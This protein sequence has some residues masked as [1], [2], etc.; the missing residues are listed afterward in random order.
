MH[1]R[2][3][4]ALE[5]AE[6]DQDAASSHEWRKQIKALWYGLR[7]LEG[8]GGAISR[9]IAALHRAEAWLGDEHN[10]VVLCAELSNDP[11]ICAGPFDL[12][13]LKVVADRYQREL[14]GKALSCARLIYG[15]RSGD[16]VRAI[17]RAWKTARHRSARRRDRPRS[18]AA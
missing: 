15:R 9:Q 14:R 3:R 17:E 1:R 4:Q 10:V 8:G 7:L 18:T 6:R 16:Y 11:S 12:Q 2:G 13:R 5:R